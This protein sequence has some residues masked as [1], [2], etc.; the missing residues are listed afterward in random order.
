MGIGVIGSPQPDDRHGMSESMGPIG[1]SRIYRD[2]TAAHLVRSPDDQEWVFAAREIDIQYGFRRRELPL[3]HG[4]AV[5]LFRLEVLI[6]RDDLPDNGDLH[7][8]V[9]ELPWSTGWS[10]AARLKP[11]SKKGPHARPATDPVLNASPDRPTA[12][13]RLA[14]LPYDPWSKG[15]WYVAGIDD[16]GPTLE[17][18]TRNGTADVEL[19][20]GLCPIDAGSFLAQLRQH[21]ALRALCQQIQDGTLRFA[22][23][24]AEIDDTIRLYPALRDDAEVMLFLAQRQALAGPN[25]PG[26][27]KPPAGRSDLPWVT[28]VD[29]I[30]RDR[31]NLLNRRV[32]RRREQQGEGEE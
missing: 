31:A 22:F 23:T 30:T 19:A 18:R 13:R 7:L 4:P 8:C 10:R 14:E 28:L 17:E 32:G 3:D 26:S 24:R 11:P 5:S 12:L 25:S 27:A 16:P 2:C 20:F 6:H 15:D 9:A 1:T 29:R 21:D